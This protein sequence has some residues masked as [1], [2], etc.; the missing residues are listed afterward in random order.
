MAGST[1]MLD[2]PTGHYCPEGVGLPLACPRG[3]YNGRKNLVKIE[4]CATCP[5]GSLCNTTGIVNTEDHLCPPGYYCTRGALVA[6]ECPVG[7][8]RSIRGGSSRSSCSRCDGGFY[9]AS[10]A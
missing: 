2:C 8:Y 5:A 1:E 3:T 10:E 6:I 7:T 4:E 9:C